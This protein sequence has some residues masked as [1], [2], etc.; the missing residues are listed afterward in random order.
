M[1]R[2]AAR[3]PLHPENLKH[4]QRA[5]RDGFPLPL[6]LR[7]HRAL[8]WLRRADAE[9][10]D[11]DVRFILLWIGFN[12]AYASDLGQAAGDDG[13]RERNVF[14]A[15]FHTLVRFDARHRIYDAVW[16]RFGQEIRLLLDNR[17]VFAPFWLHHNGVAGYANWEL[18][19]EDPRRQV[20]R[21]LR[22][23]DTATLLSLLFDRLYVL[24]NQL[25]HGG[26][27]WNSGNNRAQVRSGAALL[28]YLL[29]I[30]VDLMMDNPA[31]AWAL[32]HYPVV[33]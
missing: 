25:V 23:H 27:T 14:L 12:A 21:A 2:F 16:S 29:P 3:D 20:N 24:R 19:L 10:D 22:E 8:S 13:R 30:F 6:T 31:H 28:G 26:G 11:D 33:E 5:L 9:S 7:V 18:R 32:P 1:T 4:K 17:Y 15:F